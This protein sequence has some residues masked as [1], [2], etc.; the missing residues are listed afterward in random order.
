MS[1]SPLPTVVRHRVRW[2]SAV[3]VALATGAMSGGC[4]TKVVRDTSRPA[5]RADVAESDVTSVRVPIL[6]DF[7]DAV[8]DE[9]TREAAPRN[10]RSSG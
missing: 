10:G 8:K 5:T 6:D 2:A 1:T 4:Y 9:D 3:V 7:I